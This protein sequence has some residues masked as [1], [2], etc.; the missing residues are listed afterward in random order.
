MLS[1]NYALEALIP[2]S[3]C[4][5]KQEL[6]KE[7]WLV[8]GWHTVIGINQNC[9]NRD[10]RCQFAHLIAPILVLIITPQGVAARIVYVYNDLVCFENGYI[11]QV[12]GT[13]VI[14]G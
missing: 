2:A 6:F 3:M 12:N 1:I 11:L 9:Q 7:D 5:L 10:E 13:Q 4:G 8:G 14:E